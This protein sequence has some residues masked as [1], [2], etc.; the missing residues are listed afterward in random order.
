MTSDVAADRTTAP[1][2]VPLRPTG[3]PRPSE[4]MA[5]LGIVQLGD[6]MLTTGTRPFDLPRERDEA[7]RILDRLTATADAV[8]RVHDFVGGQMGLAAPQIGESRSIAIFRSAG[9]PQLALINPRVIEV[10]PASHS[11]WAEDTEGCLSFFDFRCTFR[12]PR[13][14]VISYLTPAGDEAVA[15]FT[16]GRLAR[17]VLHEVDHLYG[18]LCVDHIESG[19]PG[20][21][22]A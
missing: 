16:H 7:L 18:V 6:P 9:V 10:G 8:E 19:A 13:T 4:V 17:D 14:A 15:R 12:R 20:L 3:T 2:P 11:D 5:A 1:A 22:V 21:S